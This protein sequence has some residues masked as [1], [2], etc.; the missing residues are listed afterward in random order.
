[1]LKINVLQ[2]D[3]ELLREVLINA[4]K[5]CKTDVEI[6]QD[7]DVCIFSASTPNSMCTSKIAISP[8]AK[9][10]ST[11]AV[12][13]ITYGLCCKNTLTISSYIENRMVIS[14]QRSVKT[15]NGN[16]V[17][18]QDFPVII[19]D[20][21]EPELVLAAVATLIVCDVPISQISKLPF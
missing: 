16:E 13:I 20:P 7:S 8:D 3:D 5:E 14:L 12:E 18:V 15:L 1:M 11:D 4:F 2:N 9:N 17:E 6:S 21:D 19:S 10:I